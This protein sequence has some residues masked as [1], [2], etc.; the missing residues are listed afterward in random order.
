MR[1]NSSIVSLL[2]IPGVFMA[3]DQPAPLPRMLIKEA[4][5]IWEMKSP[6]LHKLNGNDSLCERYALEG[7][8]YSMRPVHQEENKYCWMGRVRT[9]KA[10]GCD[11]N[12]ENQS[13]DKFEFFDYFILFNGDASVAS[14]RI[15]SYQATHGQEVTARAWLRQFQGYTGE[16]GL[17]VGKEIDAISGATISVEAVTFDLQEKTRLLKTLLH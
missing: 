4:E 8:F 6:I 2:F 5:R 17:R 1:L 15:Y 11:F 13:R 10:G 7:A 3:F 16:G 14:V 12:T 9:C